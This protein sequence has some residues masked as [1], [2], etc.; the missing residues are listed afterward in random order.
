M[1]TGSL[2]KLLRSLL[3]A[4]AIIILLVLFGLYY[5]YNTDDM[6]KK[7]VT[8]INQK[9][10]S[11]SPFGT[12]P[13]PI[14]EPSVSPITF[15]EPPIIVT[16]SPTPDDLEGGVFRILK[17]FQ[18]PVAGYRVDKEEGLGWVVRIIEAGRGDRHQATINPY[19]IKKTFQGDG[20]YIQKAYLFKNGRVLFQFENQANDLISQSFF[21]DFVPKTNTKTVFENNV[22]VA[23]DGENKLFFIK[24]TNKG[25]VGTLVN[26]ENSAD[27][28]VIWRSNSN[29]WL[30]QWRRGK[31]LTIKT[32]TATGVPAH[33]FALNTQT[34]T[35]LP[36]KIFYSRSGGSVLLDESS[37]FL[38]KYKSIGGAMVASAD[39]G[40]EFAALYKTFTE[41]CD[42]H[43]GIFI[44]GVP[45]NLPNRTL[46]GYK[47]I[48]PD[49]WYQGDVVLSDVVVYINAVTKEQEI[50]LNP[51]DED[52]LALTSGTKFDIIHPWINDD[53]SLFFFINKRDL[54]LW[55]IGL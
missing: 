5:I 48:Y 8:T 28:R 31:Y 49:S 7:T 51:K 20:L 43:S 17:I 38:Y 11:T 23:T 39:G 37:N 30:P 19:S 36:E 44:C 16:D 41:K 22:R 42:G 15:I 6:P 27:T 3:I 18:G 32:P 10:K 45:V 54:S 13:T 46:S 1:E 24:K 14:N 2:K 26:L 33:I 4:L 40:G 12:V 55:V 50:I 25:S 52:I 9:P 53:G 21:D 29:V 34:P 35:P 47:A